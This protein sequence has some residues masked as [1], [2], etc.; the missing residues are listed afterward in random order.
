MGD[1]SW[2]YELAV[3]CLLCLLQVG[4]R[5]TKQRKKKQMNINMKEWRPWIDLLREDRID[6]F[7]ETYDMFLEVPKKD[8]K[9]VALALSTAKWIGI[10]EGTFAHATCY[11]CLVYDAGRRF[12]YG[13]NGCPLKAVNQKC[14]HSDS[15]FQKAT[16]GCSKQEREKAAEDLRDLLLKLYSKQFLRQHPK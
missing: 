1:S 7:R 6:R 3:R 2:T 14:Y 5:E 9:L 11:L 15:L 16:S 4:G 10:C 12:D 13:C 8:K